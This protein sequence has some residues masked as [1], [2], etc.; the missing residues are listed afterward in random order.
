MRVT[1]SLPRRGRQH[2]GSIPLPP[3]LSEIIFNLLRSYRNRGDD[4]SGGGGS[5]TGKEPKRAVDCFYAGFNRAEAD[6][7]QVRTEYILYLI[8]DGRNDSSLK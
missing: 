6:K 3:L 1:P 8:N 4:E 5:T 2:A 7:K